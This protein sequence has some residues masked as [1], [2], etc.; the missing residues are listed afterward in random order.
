MSSGQN[1]YKYILLPNLRPAL[2]CRSMIPSLFGRLVWGGMCVQAVDATTRGRL[3]IFQTAQAIATYFED[4]LATVLSDAALS[5][6]AESLE[7]IHPSEHKNVLTYLA[8]RL[9]LPR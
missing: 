4:D 5:V 1:G 8:G 2:A 7:T 3:A 6:G 9:S